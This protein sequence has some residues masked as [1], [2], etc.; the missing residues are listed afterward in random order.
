MDKLDPEELTTNRGLLQVEVDACTFEKNHGIN[1]AFGSALSI[2]GRQDQGYRSL[3]ESSAGQEE[4]NS[5]RTPSSDGD[6]VVYKKKIFYGLNK[7]FQKET[8]VAAV[9]IKNSTFR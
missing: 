8:F 4:V 1:V 5:S 2:D 9:K 3:Q 6:K 7:E